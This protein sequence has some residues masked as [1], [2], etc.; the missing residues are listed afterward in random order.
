MCACDQPNI[1]GYYGYRERPAAEVKSYPVTPPELSQGDVLLIDACGRC[2]GV[3]DSH[4]LHLRLVKNA[5]HYFLLARNLYA[6]RRCQIAYLPSGINALLQMNSDATYWILKLLLNT[7][8]KLERDAEQKERTFWREAI[9][10][11]RVKTRKVRKENRVDV[12]V[13]NP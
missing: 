10:Q 8:A 9:A 6:T 4:A 7:A 11:K 3:C 12:W 13:L 1:N 2:D 5:G